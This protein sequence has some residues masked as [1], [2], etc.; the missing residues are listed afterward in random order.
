MVFV[1]VQRNLKPKMEGS[2]IVTDENM[3]T[4]IH[5]LFAVG[6]VR[7][8]GLRQLVTAASDGAIAAI[9]ANKFVKNK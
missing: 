1:K 8:K 3:A 6:D 9:E 7:Q 4:N 5:G 2:F